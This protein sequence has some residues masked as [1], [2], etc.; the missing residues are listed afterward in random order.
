MEDCN[1]I[2]AHNRPSLALF[3]AQGSE[4]WGRLPRV[5]V[6]DGIERDL[7]IVGRRLQAGTV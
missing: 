3:E 7:V 1:P 5:A 2:F 6:L 4:R